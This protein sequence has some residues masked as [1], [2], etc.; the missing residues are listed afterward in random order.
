MNKEYSKNRHLIML[1]HRIPYPPNKGEKIRSFNQIRYLQKMGWNIHLCALVDDISDLQYEKELEKYCKTVTL[2]YL[3]KF[4]K[5]LTVI[6]KFF[7]GKPLSVGYFYS[8]TIQNQFNQLIGSFF[9]D[10]VLC[11]SSPMAEYL[12]CGKKI[13]NKQKNKQEPQSQNN[14]G[15][16]RDGM[17]FDKLREEWI[18]IEL[19]KHKENFSELKQITLI[20][21]TWNVNSKKPTINID[22]WVKINGGEPDM[23]ALGF[24]EIDMTAS[25]LITNDR[26]KGKCWEEHITKTLETKEE[27]YVLIKSHQLGGI[28]LCVYITKTHAPYVS[29]IEFDDVPV[30]VLGLL[31]NKGAVGIRFKLYDTKICLIN[32]HLASA[33]S[34]VTRRNTDYKNIVKN[35]LFSTKKQAQTS[36]QQTKPVI[37]ESDITFWMGDLNYRIALS[38]S[39]VRELILNKEYDKLFTNDQLKEQISKQLA[40]EHFQEGMMNFDPTYKYD[41]GTNIYDTSEKKRIPAY[42]DRV[43]FY[44]NGIRA[45]EYRRHEY[46]IS[47]HKPISAIFNLEVYYIIPDRFKEYKL[48]LIKELDKMENQTIPNAE[49]DTNNVVFEKVVYNVPVT[50]SIILS[51]IGS[52]WAKFNFVPKVNDKNICKSWLKIDKLNGFILP[53][54][55][56]E[57]KFTIHVD[58]STA[59]LLNIGKEEL[60]EIVI[61]HFENGKDHFVS[62]HG[63]Y[64]KSCFGMNLETLV[65]IEEPIRDIKEIS[66]ESEAKMIIPKEIWRLVDYLNLYG[67]DEEYIFVES[68]NIGEMEY[69]RECLDTGSAFNFNGSLHSVAE[70]LIMLLES[71]PIPIIL[72]YQKI[73]KIFSFILLLLFKIY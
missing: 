50:K 70:T 23:I 16:F 9:I 57:I 51:N 29:Q 19:H 62:I 5:L 43:L 42:C 49:L 35:L 22:D 45:R 31:G 25:T 59:H 4:R 72:S 60:D 71:F 12:I 69:L 54:T 27:K 6:L 39:Q 44:G 58:N 14:S 15:V 36:T 68:G 32:S 53:G 1:A 55:K 56:L 13:K 10:S 41:V 37:F 7:S 2:V 21:G 47:D 48:Q 30:G 61:L 26:T 40:F 52:V 24:Q 11:S 67:M 34:N 64:L 17:L 65:Q 63:E 20:C 28:L 8:K 18:D 73:I 38:N 46:L 33:F 66:K 3:S